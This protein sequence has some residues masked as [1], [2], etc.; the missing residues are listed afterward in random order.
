[1]MGQEPQSPTTPFDTTT[2]VKYVAEEH[3]SQSM[4]VRCPL[5]SPLPRYQGFQ[6]ASFSAAANNMRN[7]LMLLKANHPDE[8]R[9]N[10]VLEMDDYYSL[11]TRY[12]AEKAESKPLDWSKVYTV[13][14]PSY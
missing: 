9:E 12:L 13:N 6:H 10:F 1:M 7:H 11:F 8:G 5:P 3:R 2:P 4:N 14:C